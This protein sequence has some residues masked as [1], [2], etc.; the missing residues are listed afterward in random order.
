MTLINRTGLLLP[1]LNV[2]PHFLCFTLHHLISC[3]LLSPV[4]KLALKYHPDK[5]PDNPEAAE[6][7]KEINNANS[8]LNDETKRK[9]YDEYGSMGLYVSEQ[10]GEESVKYYFLM[11]KWWFKVGA[12]VW[13][14]QFDPLFAVTWLNVVLKVVVPSCRAWYCAVR[15]S[16]AAAVAAAAVS[17]VGNVNHQTT[18][19]T[20]STST[21]KTWRPKSKQSRTEVRGCFTELWSHFCTFSRNY[22]MQR[23][24]STMHR[25][26][27]ISVLEILSISTSQV[28]EYVR[29]CLVT[30]VLLPSGIDGLCSEVV[31]G[32][33]SVVVVFSGLKM[34]PVTDCVRISEPS[35]K[36]RGR[37]P[38]H[39]SQFSVVVLLGGVT[40]K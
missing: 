37:I 30:P 19:K 22:N 24:E 40:S 34:C 8:I 39:R 38:A 11:S 26:L 2:F 12:L 4:R 18:T 21:L 13:F 36:T 5:N 6:K 15:C 28:K 20:T 17:A 10:F 3:V 1:S 9:I 32:V 7:F 23:E 35:L 29:R 16:P 25:K 14:G 33:R 31:H 27:S